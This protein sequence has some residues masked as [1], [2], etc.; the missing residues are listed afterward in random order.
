VRREG[1][2]AAEVSK[3]LS[4]AEVSREGLSAAEVRR[5]GLSA[6]EVSVKGGRGMSAAGVSVSREEAE[7]G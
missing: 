4:A 3:G 2:S 5:E 1:L 6:A 7:C